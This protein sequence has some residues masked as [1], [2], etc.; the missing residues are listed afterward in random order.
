[1]N[2][3]YFLE[4]IDGETAAILAG[5]W[6]SGR[7]SITFD[8]HGNGTWR[9]FDTV[10]DFTFISQSDSCIT[11]NIFGVG[12][13]SIWGITSNSISVD[14][15]GACSKPDTISGTIKLL[16]RYGA[17]LSADYSGNNLIGTYYGMVN[18]YGY[19]VAIILNAD[20]TIT[21]LDRVGGK[22]VSPAARF[23]GCLR[24]GYF[25]RHRQ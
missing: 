16:T 23:P 24:L 7:F 25:N 18:Y 20:G 15:P 8:E 22:P 21:F 4:A 14:G 5:T 17:E 19:Y 1:M 13:K 11:I 6:Y 9:E 3:I 2:G 10:Y 12:S